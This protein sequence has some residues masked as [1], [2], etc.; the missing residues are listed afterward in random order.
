MNISN[1]LV[2]IQ[3]SNGDVFLSSSLINELQKKIKPKSIDLLV[4]DDT[5]AIAKTIPYVREILTFSY[6]FKKKHRWVQ[7]KKIFKKIYRKYDLSINL[8]ASDRSVIYAILA[9]KYSIS[10]IEKSSKKSWWKRLFLSSSYY[11]DNDKHIL[12]NNLKPLQ[13]LGISH[14]NLQLRAHFKKNIDEVISKKLLSL[15][16]NSFFIFHPSAQYEYKIYPKKL[17]NEL[18]QLLDSLNIPIIIT[19]S[20]NI[21]DTEIKSEIPELKNIFNWIGETS[22]EEFIALSEKSLAYIGM[23]TLNMH[24]ATS[25]DKQV[26]AIFGPTNLKMWS[27]WSNQ[28]KSSAYQNMPFQNYGN[29]SIFQADMSCVACADSGCNGTGVSRC[30]DEI[31]PIDIFNR[32][33]EWYLKL[34]THKN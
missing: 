32:I 23:D 30:L 26:F 2:I 17:R 5:V 34:V 1:I 27:P 6:D 24:I 3:R 7:E 20:K 14:K 13:Y 21:I 10:A 31:N 16:I 29:N 11:F 19:G 4:N 12:L 15:D 22:I 28:V 8:T 18:L 9:S 33:N 25:Q